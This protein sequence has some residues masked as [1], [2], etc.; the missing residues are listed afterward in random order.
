MVTKWLIEFTTDEQYNE[1]LDDTL[2][3]TWYTLNDKGSSVTLHR[4]HATK[5]HCGGMS[6]YPN[7]E[8]SHMTHK[9]IAAVS[10]KILKQHWVDVLGRDWKEVE[11][12]ELCC[13]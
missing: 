12:C 10:E 3:R 11:R 13:M 9:K 6:K 8:A 1:Y 7:G 4:G 5:R 2:K